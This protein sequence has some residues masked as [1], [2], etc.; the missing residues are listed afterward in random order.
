MSRTSK[1]VRAGH[2]LVSSS[3]T[4]LDL[5]GSASGWPRSK[6]TGGTEGSAKEWEFCSQLTPDRDEGDAAL[7][8]AHPD[9]TRATAVTLRAFSGLSDE[10]RR[11]PKGSDA[12][13]IQSIHQAAHCNCHLP[14]S[15]KSVRLLQIY[16]GADHRPLTCQLQSHP[17]DDTPYHALSYHLCEQGKKHMVVRLSLRAFDTTMAKS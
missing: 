9:G 4:K 1:E 2:V 14:N 7:Q 3:F 10:N 13:C 5:K 12:E 6:M 17:I 16:A 8:C 11:P 15:T